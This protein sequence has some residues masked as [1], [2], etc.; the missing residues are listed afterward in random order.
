MKTI[1]AMA[2]S[3][4]MAVMA[5]SWGPR[6]LEELKQETVRR[7]ERNLNPIGGVKAED[8]RE[9]MAGLKSL[10]PDE[11]AAAW[12]RIGERYFARGE[13]FHAWEVFN[14]ARWP[15]EKLSPGK[16]KA[17]ARA[18]EAFAL[19]GKALNPPI[20]TVR[21]PFE[22]KEIVAYLR[23]PAGVRPAPLVFGINGLDSRKEEVI[24]RVERYLKAG[25]GVFA[26]DMPG[27]G[28]APLLIDVGAERMFSKALDYLATRKDVDAKRIVAQGRSWSGYWAAM[29]AYTEKDRILGAVVHGVGIDKY[30]SP[31]WQKAAFSTREY[32]FDIYP[33]RAVV[34]GTT[35]MDEFL[36]YGPRL[37][38]AT[39]GMLERPSAP[40][41]LV[42][43]E[44][45]T[46]QPISDLYLLMRHGDPKDV[47]VNP[48]GGHMGRSE[49]WPQGKVLAEVVEPW[50]LRKLGA[51]RVQLAQ[52]SEVL[53]DQ[54]KPPEN[55]EPP[56]RPRITLKPKGGTGSNVGDDAPG[57]GA[58]TSQS[59]K[60]GTPGSPSGS[61]TGES[62]RP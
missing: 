59:S 44:R 5:Q 48:E 18:L 38:L 11:W 61:F 57:G 31:E 55:A 26:I 22:G 7:A 17:Y 1:L 23:L 30:F 39:R 27:T 42:N 54:K 52:Q 25:V 15:S 46:Q 43:G 60:G 2:L 4:P 10:E 49:R 62:A 53:K 51:D 56:A 3:L 33:A 9:A 37:S 19:Y 47:W 21:I 32:L 40:M 8:A 36:A 24:A 6:S 14:V 34:Y 45:D 41:L 20:E 28:Q 50:V 12:S 58:R 13:Y 29:M 35:S 16:Q